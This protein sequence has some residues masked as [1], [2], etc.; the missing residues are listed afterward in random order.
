MLFREVG[1]WKKNLASEDEK[2][3]NDIIRKTLEYRNA[4]KNSSEPK[5]AQLWC[6]I[7]V[8]RN[9]MNALHAKTR[10]MEEIYNAITNAVLRTE[11]DKKDLLRSLEN[12]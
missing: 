12:Y 6:A 8:L 2:R 5:I 10:R 1:D 9:E 4:Y 3:L 7:L 11:N